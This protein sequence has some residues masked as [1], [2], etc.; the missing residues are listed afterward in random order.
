MKKIL[1]FMSAVA[2][3]AAASCNK[4]EIEG[5]Q[6][7]TPSVNVSGDA[8][9]FVAYTESATKTALNGLET[10]WVAGDEIGINGVNYITFENGSTVVFEKY[11]DTD[12]TLEAPYV[13]TYPYAC[14]TFD[15][16]EFRCISFCN[17]IDLSE[18]NNFTDCVPAIAYS[19]S[20]T[21]L[22]F[23]NI[24]SLIKFQVPEMDQPITEIR[25]SAN[26]ELAGWISVDYTKEN[27]PYTN[28]GGDFYKELIV[29][30]KDS[31]ADD[32]VFKP[33]EF[34]YVPALPGLKTN[35][36]FKIN[37]KVVATGISMELKRNVIHNIAT[38]PA[39][40]KWAIAGTFNNWNTSATPMAKEGDFYVAKGITGLNYTAKSDSEESDTGFKFV[41]NG[42][43]WKGSVG[44]MSTNVWEYVWDADNGGNIYV[45]DSD[46]TTVYD[47]YV[48][49]SAGDNGKFVIVPAGS[50]MPKDV[51][52]WAIAGTCNGWNTTATPMLKE[53]DFYV[54]KG[55]TG[56]NYTAKDNSEE[57]ETGFKF[58]L[59][60]DTWK[61]GEGKAVAATWAYIWGGGD[62]K[63]IYVEGA[64]AE[65]AYDIYVNP[66]K[67]DNGKYVIVPAGEAMPEDKPAG[68][69]PGQDSEWAVYAQFGSDTWTEVVMKTTAQE[70]LF[71]VEKKTMSA[72]NKLLIKKYQ[73]NWTVKY[74]ASS[75]NYIKSN[76]Y[77]TVALNGG[78]IFVEA[79]GTYDIYFDSTNK[80]VYLM[81]AGSD[82]T[83]ATEQ[84]VNGEKP[85]ASNEKTIYL[86]TGGSTLWDQGGA[87]FV[88]WIWGG[89]DQ[90]VTFKSTNESGIYSAVVPKGTTGMICFR[91]GPGMTNGW[92][93]DTN[94]WNRTNGDITL[95]GKNCIKITGWGSNGNST[96]SLSTK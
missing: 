86:N 2:M 14:S 69:V 47:I 5:P 40:A 71:V 65:T 62:G 90:W 21:T 83:S 89:G 95:N 66:S 20:E 32:T 15:D 74:G 19:E 96:W 42:S 10:V 3:L 57:S 25:I 36:T 53:G 13:A 16:G 7:E 29:T 54:A 11:D 49:P 52:A 79:D 73:D 64:A 58:I 80:Y 4:A 35:L 17:E 23:K 85:A 45:K 12:L 61:G 18:P 84:T 8:T 24:T 38:L 1:L 72:Y 87:T 28:E 76:R 56:L 81:T 60:G 6:T 37:D 51:P 30:V 93:K 55:I 75:V 50:E 46:A 59:N 92:A 41:V 67:G 88:A 39:A 48:N 91:K 70:G 44:E 22:K 68:P 9:Q 63:N 33:G 94:Y 31:N 34:Y 77:F 78:D 43:L 27:L 82:Y 26:E